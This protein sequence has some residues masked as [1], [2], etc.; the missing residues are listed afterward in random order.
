MRI[1]ARCS[2]GLLWL[3]S[4]SALAATDVPSA[5]DSLQERL[6]AVGAAHI[7]FAP[8]QDG[9]SA[10]LTDRDGHVVATV[11]SQTSLGERVFTWR[12]PDQDA[13]TVRWSLATGDVSLE[14]P[15]GE[16]FVK[17]MNRDAQ[18]FEETE[19][20]KTAFDRYFP[21]IAAMVEATM[22]AETLM[23]R[24]VR[25]TA[26]GGSPASAY[27][28]CTGSCPMFGRVAGHS[29]TTDRI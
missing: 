7:S 5:A 17:T 18:M 2:L 10:D 15:S 14:M 3:L 16:R 26:A 8:R 29:L 11:T 1:I 19:E 13:F 21:Q 4:L 9:H 24:P 23:P 22:R 27:S 25:A 6:R 20:T 12:T 28:E